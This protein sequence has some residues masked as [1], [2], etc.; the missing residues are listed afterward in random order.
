LSPHGLAGIVVLGLAVHRA[1]RILAVDEMPWLVRARRWFLGLADHPSGV[2]HVRRPVL[3][4]WLECP[5]CAGAWLTVVGYVAW[6]CAPTVAEPA[7]VMLAASTIVGLVV[8]N[9]DPTED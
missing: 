2:I 4:K 9:L 1:W 7:I 8:R 6:R 3:K 5:W